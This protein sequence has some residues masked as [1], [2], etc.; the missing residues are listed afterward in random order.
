M[1]N[2]K[3]KDKNE[4]NETVNYTAIGMGIGLI[5]GS[6]PDKKNSGK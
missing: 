2:K 6:V 4:Q 3:Q 1:Q 5:I